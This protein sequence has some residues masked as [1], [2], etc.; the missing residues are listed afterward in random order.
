MTFALEIRH[1]A[2]VPSTAEGWVELED[3]APLSRRPRRAWRVPEVTLQDLQWLRERL[4]FAFLAPGDYRDDRPPQKIL[5]AYDTSC[6]RDA[7]PALA[8]RGAGPVPSRRRP[9]QAPALDY[10]ASLARIPPA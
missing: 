1:V 9:G 6:T 2:L 4:M 7:F 10:V 3:A 8:G 5:G